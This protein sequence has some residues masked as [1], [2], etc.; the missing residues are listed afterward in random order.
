M[1]VEMRRLLLYFNW[2]IDWW[3]ERAKLVSS[4]AD[5]VANGFVIY[6]NNQVSTLRKIGL[7]FRRQWMEE[8]NIVD[9]PKVSDQQLVSILVE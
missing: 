1:K 2:K 9:L 8:C 4:R 7:R 3:I 6:A 5:R